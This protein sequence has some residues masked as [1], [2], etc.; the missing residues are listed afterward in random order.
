[1]KTILEHLKDTAAAILGNDFTV[2]TG[3][4]KSDAD[5]AKSVTS[6]PKAVY[7]SWNGHRVNSAGRNYAEQVELYMFTIKVSTG[8]DAREYTKAVHDHFAAE[9]R[10]NR[11]VIDE[12]GL[13][14][15]IRLHNSYVEDKDGF[16]IVTITVEVA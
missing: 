15:I 12:S 14:R 5:F 11:Q 7:I 13:P 1:M 2:T 10:A 3:S 6:G 9:I 4:G 8:L 16:T